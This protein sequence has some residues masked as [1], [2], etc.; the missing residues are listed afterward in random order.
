MSIDWSFF[1]SIF[2]INLLERN[3]RYKTSK[4]LFKRLNIPVTYFR[5]KKHPNGGLQGCMESHIQLINQAYKQKCKNILIFEDDVVIDETL[6]HEFPAIMAKAIDFMRNNTWDLFFLGPG[7]DIRYFRAEAT[8]HDS[9]YKVHSIYTHAYVISRKM[10]KNLKGLR[11]TGI[12]YDYILR[13]NTSSYAIY[14]AP[15]FQSMIDSDIGSGWSITD[16]KLLET[17]W[18]LRQ[19]YSYNINLPLSRTNHIVLIFLIVLVAI[20][21]PI[22]LLAVIL[23]YIA[24]F[25]S[26]K[27]L[28][29]DSL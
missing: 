25:I 9:I 21:K 26:K 23:F 12:P 5:T 22:L 27:Y 15:F 11:F 13:H 20:N 3:D 24:I 19:W 8:N 10:M 1:D 28:L 7:H 29:Q 16:P 18:K 2:C 4:K 17:F 14:P 6:L